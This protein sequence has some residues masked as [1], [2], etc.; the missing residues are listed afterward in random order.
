MTYYI[1]RRLVLLPVS[2]LLLAGVVFGLS[3]LTPGDPV[4]DWLAT[5]AARGAGDDP[6]AYERAYAAAA[7]RRGFDRPPFYLTLTNRATPDTLYRIPLPE[8]RAAFRTATELTADP[9]A[10]RTYWAALRDC[11]YADTTPGPL[12]ARCRQ[13]LVQDDPRRLRATLGELAAAGQAPAVTAAFGRAEAGAP[14]GRLLLPRLIWHGADNQFHRWL[15]G[16][17]GGDFGVSLRDRRP[18]AAKLVGALRWTAL[19]N[20]LALVVVYLVALPLGM[21]AA[22]YRGGWFDRL[23]S[24]LLFLLF[25]IPSFWVATLLTNFF[26]T[27]AFGMD[28]FPSMGFGDVPPGAGWWT[29]LRIRAAHLFLPVLCL[30]YPAWAYV[31]R[32]LRRSALAELGKPYVA[33]ARLKGLGTG[34]VLWGHVFRNASF[35]LITLL[36]G[37]LPAMLAGSVLIERIFNLPGM[38]QLLYAA[39]LGRDWPVVLAVVLLTGLLTVLGLLLADLGYALVDPRLRLG[40]KAG[41]E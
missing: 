12:A 17:L 20:G 18:V 37:V 34:A 31:S 32:H 35:P 21:Y 13:L 24:P 22:A 6:L 1:L 36:A 40:G 39:A 23:S 7:A 16:V 38:G 26:T 2:L 27:P 11:A 30:A 29:A 3:R 4:A 19:L 28:F 14:R 9:A 5:D 8:Q 15:T 10:T 25:G 33:T 41:A